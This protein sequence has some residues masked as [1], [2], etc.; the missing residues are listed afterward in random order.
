MSTRFHSKFHRHNHHTDPSTDPRFPDSAY[1]PIASPDSPFL[2][3]FVLSGTLIANSPLSSYTA[4]IVNTNNTALILD[5][6]TFALSANGGT[7]VQNITCENIVINKLFTV[8]ASLVFNNDVG[9]RQTLSVSGDLINYRDVYIGN[10][11]L[12][13]SSSSNFVGINTLQPNHALTINGSVSGLESAFFDQSLHVGNFFDVDSTNTKI[14]TPLEVRNSAL[15]TGNLDLSGNLSVAQNTT[16]AKDLRVG[17]N[18]LFV[19]NTNLRVGIRTGNPTAELT[20][21]GEVSASN[22]VTVGDILS[23]GR[24]TLYALASSQRVGIN[25][26][27]PN[28]ALTISGE[29]SSTGVSTFGSGVLHVDSVNN[30]V[31]INTVVPNYPLT[32]VG[33][34]SSTGSVV[35]N[36]SL[37]AGSTFF[38]DSTSKRVGVNTVFPN[39]PLTVVGSISATEF[40]YAP[41]VVLSTLSVHPTA[42]PITGLVTSLTSVTASDDFV[43]LNLNGRQRAL[44][45]WDF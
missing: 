5:G 27:N 18:S 16:L 26:N 25:T 1:D 9:V 10:E 45:L 6:N 22:R 43:I 38:V 8:F 40:L 34:I 7:V 44:R 36:S 31:G 28:R 41:T 24:T 37:S 19:N 32:V 23:V 12:F 2:G 20:V 33:E 29:V 35:F 42:L 21:N 15:I 17:P 30:R 13:I 11:T 39:H 3:A 4:H 14:T